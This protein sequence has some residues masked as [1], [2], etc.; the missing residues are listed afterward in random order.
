MELSSQMENKRQ[1]NICQISAGYHRC[2]CSLD[3]VPKS[4]NNLPLANNCQALFHISM[5]STFIRW[6]MQRYLGS[7][8]EQLS[9]TDDITTVECR[10]GAKQEWTSW[11]KNKCLIRGYI[12]VKT[13]CQEEKLSTNTDGVNNCKKATKK[14]RKGERSQHIKPSLGASRCLLITHLAP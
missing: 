10:R 4:L 5:G 7:H 2:F 11:T 9:D 13:W 8:S 3:L 6:Q 1:I 14:K 12:Q